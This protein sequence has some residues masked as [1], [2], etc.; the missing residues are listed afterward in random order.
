MQ[1]Q[2]VN[3]PSVRKTN[4][5]RR[6]GLGPSALRVIGIGLRVLKGLSRRLGV[7]VQM[8]G[9]GMGHFRRIHYLSVLAER[10]Q[11]TMVS[12][13]VT[14]LPV[15]P[16]VTPAESSSAESSSETAAGT[17]LET[18]VE[19]SAVTA[20]VMRRFGNLLGVRYQM[21]LLGVSHFRCIDYLAVVGQRGRWSV[22]VSVMNVV[23]LRPIARQSQRR[24]HEARQDDLKE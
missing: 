1:S 6:R 5:P 3:G 10:C 23:H 14:S 19:T 18:S 13:D 12:D 24:Q 22:I 17:S 20:T 2:R 7:G 21:R 4:V 15:A 9:L 16:A 8:R 11:F